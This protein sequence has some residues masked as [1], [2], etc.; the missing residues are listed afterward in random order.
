MVLS[1]HT[2]G[3]PMEEFPIALS[4]GGGVPKS[5]HG[6][7]ISWYMEELSRGRSVPISEHFIM[8]SRFLEE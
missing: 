5:E 8:I 7:V 6:M 4:T 1:V 2:C 3:I